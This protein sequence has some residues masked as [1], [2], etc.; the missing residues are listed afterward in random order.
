MT[1]DS[2]AERAEEQ[3]APLSV[4][5]GR[6]RATTVGMLTLV[7]IAAFEHL[8]VSTAMP[9][10]V[11]ELH[12]EAL[13]SWP[14]TAFLAASVMATVL[15]GRFCDRFG[16]G[17][18]LVT[19]PGLF[20]AGLVASGFATGMPVLLVGRVL[21]GLGLGTQTVAI[22]VLVALVYPNRSRA[23]VFGL[24]AAAWVVP[25][26]VGPTA[27]GLITEHVGWRWVF[28]G[29]APFALLGVLLLLPVIR[30][31]PD[32]VRD[33][34]QAV[35]RG[36]GVA[37]V[38]TAFGIAALTWAAQH[39]SFGMI[40]LGV[41]GLAAL[42]P[43]LRILMPRGTFTARPG[44]PATVLMR[45]LLAGAFFGVEAYVP[46]TLSSVHGFSPAMSGV[47]L[48]V[49]AIGWAGASH[50]QGRKPDLDR[51]RLIRLGLVALAAALA[52]MT[53]VGADW[54]LAWL[55][56]PFWLVAGT[57]MGLSYPSINVLSL[58]Y[59]VPGDRGFVSSALQ[60]N[61]M[62]FSAISVGLG[63]VMLATFASTE[64]P[65]AAI[66]PLDLLLACLALFGACVFRPLRQAS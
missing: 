45:G 36:L 9:R 1:I 32:H 46:L 40:W 10:M 11:A 22:Y 33:E 31:L 35:R 41:A 4:W 20:L 25:S 42:V 24:L 57:A 66:V 30:T 3:V 23:A 34:D 13:Y 14:F 59:A 37:A 5:S 43:A 21:Q 55:V 7:T 44:L 47:P 26:L 39:P 53:L 27:A 63:G 51:V 49:G 18:A 12:G 60:V 64:A 29:I 17:R 8:G 54:G 38:A 50:W 62:T 19:G 48:T 15:S 61:D 2:T 56:L 65:S 16:P 58:D 52:C 6:Y 28:L